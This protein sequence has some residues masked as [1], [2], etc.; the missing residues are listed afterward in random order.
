MGTLQPVRLNL[1][2]GELELAAVPVLDR[3]EAST[4][5]GAGLIPRAD[6]A[7]KLAA[8]WIP[9]LM[10]AQLPVASDGEVSATKVPRADDSRL[11]N[12]PVGGDLSGTAAS[13]TVAKL[14]GRT[15]ANDAPADGQ[16]LVWNQT[17]DQWEPAAVGGDAGNAT[18]IQGRD[19]ASAAPT[20]GDAL[21]WS[22]SAWAPDQ[23]E[24]S[25]VGR[26]AA[27]RLYLH[28]RGYR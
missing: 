8:G 5:A 11:G 13:A 19:V 21:V 2:T 10:L 12:P 1:T 3:D 14:Q 27:T 9:L 6:G 4:A 26:S 20:V 16:G 7:G 15:V 25:G 18:Q 24:G 23:V 28:S 22:G 17:S